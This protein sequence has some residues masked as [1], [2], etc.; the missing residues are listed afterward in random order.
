M[1]FKIRP[2]LLALLFAYAT[3]ACSQGSDFK[4]SIADFQES[5]ETV[6]AAIKSYYAEL[7]EYERELYLQERLMDNTLRVAIK[8]SQGNP[9]PL[10]FQPFAP[11]ALQGR[12][13]LLLQICFYGQQLA[14]LAGNASPG[15]AKKN[16]KTVADG[17]STLNATFDSLS[18]T[19]D[20]AAARYLGPMGALF[21]VVSKPLLEKKR[22]DAIKKAVREGQKP[23][24]AI[25]T[26]LE[27]DLKKYVE[28]TRNTG[29]RLEVAEW[30]NY[31]NRNIGKL[32]FAQRQQVLQHI[33]RTAEELEL[34]KQ[35]QPADVVVSLR[36]T[37]LALVKYAASSGKA[38]DLASLQR[39]VQA[40]HDDAQQL[41]E[42][43]IALQKLSRQG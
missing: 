30:V 23:I 8:D 17:L 37:H 31:Y 25:L 21:A 2:F 40:F 29:H 10:L 41:V 36:E 27:Q 24:N 42:A 28:T 34:A 15:Q 12:I 19:N 9:T 3:F 32:S 18:K 14:A 4:A 20:R 6:T 5:T 26:F 35:A 13:E 22:T 43:V 38:R 16:L 7:N 11:E 33:K 39:A 1:G